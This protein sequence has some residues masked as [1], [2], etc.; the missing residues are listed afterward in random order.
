MQRDPRIVVFGQD[1]A[2]TSHD[3][4]CAMAW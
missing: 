4:S 1:V 3:R 2:D